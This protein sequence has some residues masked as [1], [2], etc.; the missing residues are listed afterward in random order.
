MR[1]KDD[2]INHGSKTLS[3]DVFKNGGFLYRNLKVSNKNGCSLRTFAT[4]QIIKDSPIY[5]SRAKKKTFAMSTTSL[6][7]TALHSLYTF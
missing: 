3:T 7:H 4:L 1:L 5:F 2:R 6:R